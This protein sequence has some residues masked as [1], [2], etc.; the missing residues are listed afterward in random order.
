MD[1][2]LIFDE[3]NSLKSH[4]LFEMKKFETKTSHNL[5]QDHF[6]W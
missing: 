5:P 6:E 4:K 2:L 3:L 1:I